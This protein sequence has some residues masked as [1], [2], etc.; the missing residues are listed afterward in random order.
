MHMRFLLI[1][2]AL[3]SVS[4]AARATYSIA[5][6]DTAMRT[7]GVAVQTN[8]L[9]V[10]ASVPYAK[11]GVGAIAS[12]FETNPMYGPRGLALLAAGKSPEETAKQL[13]SEDGNF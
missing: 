1:T 6:C 13:L 5:A 10:G 12:Q 7:C 4:P 2:A 8:N 9:A 3:L 11:T